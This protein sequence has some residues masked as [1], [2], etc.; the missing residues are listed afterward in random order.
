[1]LRRITCSV[2]GFFDAPHS[3]GLHSRY[4]HPLFLAERL[5]KEQAT[6][7]LS[8]EAMPHESRRMPQGSIHG[9]R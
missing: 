5:R 9:A 2:I 8:A 6:G 7:L 4:I 3:W 1:M